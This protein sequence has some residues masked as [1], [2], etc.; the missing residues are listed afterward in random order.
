MAVLRA[1]SA[2]LLLLATARAS[3]P[4][5][6]PA[7]EVPEKTLDAVRADLARRSGAT[8][9]E[10]KVVRA[11]EVVFSDGSL[12]CARPG[13]SYTQATVPGYRVIVVVAGKQYDYRVTRRG[14][15]LLCDRARRLR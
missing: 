9:E 13:Q 8:P 4:A 15:V 12:G 6:P 3:D 2:A 1:L 10:M 14:S 7:G 5:A 11:E